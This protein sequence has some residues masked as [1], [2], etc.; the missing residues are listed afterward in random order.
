VSLS[1]NS[2]ISVRDLVKIYPNGLRAVDGISFGVSRGTVFSLLGPNG[3][4]KTTTVEILE[5]LRTKTTGD[6]E[7]FSQ[8]IG[9]G[10]SPPK[11]KIGILPQDF[12][13]LDDLTAAEMLTYVVDLGS[14]YGQGTRERVT[15]LLGQVGLERKAKTLAE[16]LSGGEK[17]KLGIALSLANDPELVFLDEPTTGL[18]PSA[19]REVWN[20]IER[21]QSQQKTILLTTHYLEEAERLADHIAILNHGKILIAGT[22]T[23]VILSQGWR[24]TAR[25]MIEG[26]GGAATLDSF[27]KDLVR[28]G[29]IAEITLS[30]AE[31]IQGLL[32]A[33]NTPGYRLI[34][35]RSPTLEDVYLR[36]VGE[37]TE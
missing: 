30:R 19:R 24:Y 9:N 7:I 1:E 22:P 25:V 6:I 35:V 12:E 11:D 5:G 34:E 2:V 26:T 3:A 33:I 32:N 28:R 31:D 15:E 21:L 17:R 27:E 16:K 37:A 10:A 8:K 23:D 36:L 29:N 4:G 14:R 18:D 13:V 20:L